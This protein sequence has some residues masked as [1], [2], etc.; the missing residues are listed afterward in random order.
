MSVE[1][2]TESTSQLPTESFN[3]SCSDINIDYN[4]GKIL[5]FN[6]IYI[7]NIKL[8]R[9]ILTYFYIPIEQNY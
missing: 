7:I 6:Q 1:I 4:I 8:F 5:I 3:P 2:V 9:H